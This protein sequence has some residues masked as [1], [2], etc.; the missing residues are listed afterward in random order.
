MSSIAIQS[1][2]ERHTQT[3]GTPLAVPLMIPVHNIIQ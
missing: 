2:V 3:E 1:D